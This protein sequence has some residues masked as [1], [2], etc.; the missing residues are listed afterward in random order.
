MH[1][2][3]TYNSQS[4]HW[5]SAYDLNFQSRKQDRNPRD[6]FVRLDLK[7][8]DL[9]KRT[10]GKTLAQHRTCLVPHSSSQVYGKNLR[11]RKGHGTTYLM[12]SLAPL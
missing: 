5:R 11:L 12:D 8:T 10:R 7:W 2:H 4:G 9:H 3:V 6:E 1:L